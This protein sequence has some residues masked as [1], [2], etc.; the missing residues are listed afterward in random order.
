MDTS[1][2]SEM[3]LRAMYIAMKVGGPILIICLVIGIVISIFQA[4][5]QI[6]E[7]GLIFVPKL[8]AVVVMLAVMG[9]WMASQLINF[10]KEVFLK[11]AGM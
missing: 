6:H 11:I 10:T 3:A 9:S 5:T 4:T 7:Q 1:A 8:V 2:I